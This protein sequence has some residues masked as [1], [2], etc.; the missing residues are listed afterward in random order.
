MPPLAASEERAEIE[1]EPR[2]VKDLLIEMKDISELIV[3]LAYSAIIFDSEEI[4]Q[5]VLRLEQRMYRLRY[6]LRL[7][8]MLSTRTLQ[9][10]Q[11]MLGILQVSGAGGAIA[12]AAGDIVKILESELEYRPLTPFI[13]KGS[14]ERIRLLTIEEAS[15]ITGKTLGEMQLETKFGIRMVAVR[16]GKRWT[17][18]ISEEAVL[19]A[20][21][22]AIVIGTDEG[23]EQLRQVASGKRSFEEAEAALGAA[24][25]VAPLAA[26]PAPGTKSE[27]ESWFIEIKDTS[28]LMVD[29]AY[30]AILYDSREIAEEVATLEE[31][32]DELVVKLQR[33]VL[34]ETLETKNIDKALLLF[35]LSNSMEQIADA[36][37][38]IADT[39][40]REIQVHPV[41]VESLRESDVTIV[42][43]EVAPESVFCGKT[44]R[45]TQL[46]T[47]TG[48]R[49][50]A[51]RRG[52]KWIVGP[53]PED[54][55]EAHDVLFARGPPASEGR[56]RDLCVG[57]RRRV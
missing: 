23:I 54:K 31:E 49:V 37:R 34:E 25:A 18:E 33:R 7:Q 42:R 45:Q 51:I 8:V 1:Y 44:L 16:R 47:K 21:D 38:E 15:A 52:K 17:Y 14:G 9:D 43:F 26:P 57:K 39:A 53:G 12:N 4:A 48:M 27:T 11:M 32:V 55:I 40:L 36:A 3:D 13:L 24:A 29:L 6:L 22:Q 35:A 41:L 50:V 46:A 19:K 30:S 28:D 20:G 2:P 5:E 56:L 10:A